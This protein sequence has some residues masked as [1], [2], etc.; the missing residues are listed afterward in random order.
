MTSRQIHG[1]NIR[2]YFRSI[3]DGTSLKSG[4][5]LDAEVLTVFKEV[6][7][8][9]QI[10]HQR[11]FVHRDIGQLEV[12]FER[13]EPKIKVRLTDFGFASAPGEIFPPEGEGPST[14]LRSFKFEQVHPMIEG[15]KRDIDS[16]IRIMVSYVS[17]NSESKTARSLAQLKELIPKYPLKEHQIGRAHV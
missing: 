14:S 10:F 4:A 8:V 16:L 11:G 7:K 3:Q 9:L 12:F 2:E 15:P 13:G 1:M 17:V 5:E 6:V